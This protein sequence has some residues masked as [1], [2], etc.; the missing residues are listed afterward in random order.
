M[1]T[2]KDARENILDQIDILT[3]NFE[4]IQIQM[5]NNQADMENFRKMFHS[6][7]EEKTVSDQ[8]SNL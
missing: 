7:A 6:K 3:E 4:D 8:N 1:K 2:S 5:K